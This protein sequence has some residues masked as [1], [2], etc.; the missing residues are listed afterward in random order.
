MPVAVRIKA[1]SSF[2]LSTRELQGVRIVG[3]VMIPR[4]P[5]PDSLLSPKD[6]Q[7][8]LPSLASLHA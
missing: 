1:I 3:S 7:G 6:L 5:F 4:G 8:F 2:L